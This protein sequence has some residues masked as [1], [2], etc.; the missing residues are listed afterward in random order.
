MNLQNELQIFIKI[1]KIININN[2]IIISFEI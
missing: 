1:F 2:Y